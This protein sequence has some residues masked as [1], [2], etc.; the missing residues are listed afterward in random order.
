MPD[1]DYRGFFQRTQ[2]MKRL[3]IAAEDVSWTER[4]EKPLRSYQYVLYLGCNVLRTPH[5]AADVVNVFRALDLDFVAVGG[6]QFCCG[7]TWEGAGDTAIGSQVS[8]RTI[9]RLASYQPEAVVMWCPSCDVHFDDVVLGRDGRSVP[10]EITHTTALLARLADEGRIGWKRPVAARALVH[11]HAGAPD[12]ESGQRRATADKLAASTL[13]RH[14]PG[15]QLTGTL[16]SPPDLGYDCAPAL[17]RLGRER[18]VRVRSRLER[19]AR[20][21]A[22]DTLVTISHACHREWCE[23]ADDALAVR[24]YISIVADALEIQRTYR[25]SPLTQFKQGLSPTEIVDRSIREW[26]SYGMER[27]EAEDVA[28]RYFD[29]QRDP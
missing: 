8:G 26:Q 16:E 20:A 22:A 13:L 11:A 2:D 4:Y 7:I 24:N 19:R 6:V 29:G 28:S 3:Q 18:F 27:S 15:V 25:E 17:V 10:F 23:I 9:E 14:I 12:H 5:I 21:T 1:F